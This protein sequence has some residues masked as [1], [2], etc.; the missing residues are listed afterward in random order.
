MRQQAVAGQACSNI[1]HKL[2]TCRPASTCLP[3]MLQMA[4]A[5]VCP[6]SEMQQRC[7][8]R[9]CATFTFRTRFPAVYLHLH[10]PRHRAHLKPQYD[11]L[12]MITGFSFRLRSTNSCRQMREG[13]NHAPN[14][15]M[16]SPAA[17]IITMRATAYVPVRVRGC[18]YAGRCITVSNPPGVSWPRPQSPP[19]QGASHTGW[20]Q[21]MRPVATEFNR[22]CDMS[23][24]RVIVLAGSGASCKQP[25]HSQQQ[26]AAKATEQC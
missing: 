5:A 9:G 7:R 2:P 3:H 1:R 21:P 26:P 25:L 22:G 11:L 4:G 10:M 12:K 19:A 23:K 16:L 20:G 15:A 14:L 17:G 24:H 6:S 13:K 18:A 8:G